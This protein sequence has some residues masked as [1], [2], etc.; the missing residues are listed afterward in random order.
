MPLTTCTKNSL[1]KTKHTFSLLINGMIEQEAIPLQKGQPPVEKVT[2]GDSSK[3]DQQQDILH[4][5]SRKF[6]ARADEQQVK[7][8][9]V[10]DVEGVQ[11]NTS[12]RKKD[13]P[14]KKRRTRRQNQRMSQ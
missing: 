6:A 2:A 3:T 10:G 5:M 8:V 11:R 12:K 13:N 9:V 4:K 1:N 14:K 7:T